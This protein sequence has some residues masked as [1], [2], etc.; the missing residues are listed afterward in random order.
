MWAEFAVNIDRDAHG[1]LGPNID[2][3]GALGATYEP[4]FFG[5]WE[6]TAKV[7]ERIKGDRH[8]EGDGRV[9]LVSAQLENVPIRYVRG[10]HGGLPNIPD[11]YED[12]FRCL[13]KEPMQ[14]PASV[15]E[16]L[17]MHLAAEEASETPHL[18]ATAAAVP[19]TDDAGLWQLDA[20]EP[21]RFAALAA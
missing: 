3:F 11:V 12:V 20:P 7:T 13:R 5:L 8:R 19:F 10:V 1:S 17:S 9:P 18:D 2:M 15:D 6:R 16:A 14:L 21:E 4:K